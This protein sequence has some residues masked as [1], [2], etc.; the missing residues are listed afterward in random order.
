MLKVR[1]VKHKLSCFFSGVSDEIRITVS[2]SNPT[3][4]NTKFAL[5][6]I[7]EGHVLS[8]KRTMKLAIDEEKSSILGLPK[9]NKKSNFPVEKSSTAQTREIRK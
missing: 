2:M 8:N 9:S 3:T 5:V 4:L 6:K 7:Q 1:H